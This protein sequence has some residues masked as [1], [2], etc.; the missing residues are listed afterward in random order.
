MNN[1]PK[2]IGLRCSIF[3]SKSIGYTAE[4]ELKYKPLLPN[5]QVKGF[6]PNVPSELNLGFNMSL[7]FNAAWQL[8]D[9]E[10][11]YSI[12]FA[13]QKIDILFRKSG[14]ENAKQ[15]F[16]SFSIRVFTEILEEGFC[17]RLAFSPT[18]LM[19]SEDGFLYPDYWKSILKNNQILNLPM[20]NINLQYLLRKDWVNE[21]K[22]IKIN[23]SHKWSDAVVTKTINNSSHNSSCI[24][25]TLD[26]NTVPQTQLQFSKK[27]VAKFFPYTEELT[28]DLLN[29]YLL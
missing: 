12:I 28:K 8:E 2:L 3:L 19:D 22:I 29:C 5:A 4:N 13:P 18:Y 7:G 11:G 16:M 15:R 9:K 27:D 23:L 20:K 1:Q 26:I 6:T 10:S 25:L 17:N 14:D 24:I 21:G